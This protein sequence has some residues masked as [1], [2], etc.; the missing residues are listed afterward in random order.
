MTRDISG[1]GLYSYSEYPLSVGLEAAFDL[2][3]P[4]ELAGREPVMFHCQGRVLRSEQFHSRIGVALSITSHH[5]IDTAKF[6]RRSYERVVPLLP[7]IAHYAGSQSEVRDLSMTGAFIEDHHP[8][9]V[10]RKIGLGLH[11]ESHRGEIEVEEAVVRRVTPATG[12][13]VEFVALTVDSRRRLREFLR[14]H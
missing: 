8:L 12:M 14:R 5:L 11:I 3:F 2:L 6:Y 7:M 9:P 13:G 4:A 1:T 10:D